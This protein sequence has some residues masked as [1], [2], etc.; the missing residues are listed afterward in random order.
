LPAVAIHDDI[1]K[2]YEIDLLGHIRILKRFWVYVKPYRSKF[3]LVFLL[4]LIAVPLQQF[5]IFL[6]RDVTNKALLATD[7]TF[8]ERWG[9]VL[10]IVGIQ[11]AFWFLSAI[12]STFREVLEWYTSMRATFD[13]R[14][15]FYKHLHRLPMTFLRQRPAGEQLYRATN[16]FGGQKQVD[17][18]GYDPGVMGMICRQFPQ[19]A[20]KAYMLIWGGVFL[21]MLDPGLGLILAVYMVPYL[22]VGWFLYDRVRR[23]AFQQRHRREIETGVLRDSIAGLRTVKS[24]GR[25][26]YQN[27]RYLRSAVLSGRRG[28]QQMA[29]TV[30]ADHIGLGGLRW[31]FNGTATAYISYRVLSGQA[32]VGD[33]FATVALLTAAQDPWEK[34]FTFV[35]KI[36]MDMV[37]AQRLLETL[38]VPIEQGDKADAQVLT[39]LEGAV[40]Y[41]DV[42]F[43]YD[44]GKPALKGVSFKVEP[45]E[46]I[47]FVGPSG[48]GKSSVL[49][50]LLR[51]YR[52]DSGQ[53]LVDG[54]DLQDAKLD[55]YLRFVGVVPQSTYLYDG[56][57]ADNILFG[58]K[59]A[60]PAELRQVALESGVAA[61]AARHAEGLDKPVGEGATISGG[62]RQ[63]IGIARALIR[64]PR[65]FV[66]DEATANLDAGTEAALL[67]TLRQVSKGRT[68]MIVAHRLKAVA[69]C[70]RI[71]VLDQGQ[72]VEVGKHEEL[73]KSGG[74]YARLWEEQSEETTL[75][76][77]AGGGR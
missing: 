73:I 2:R 60:T 34:L 47:G 28:M 43:S 38:D 56:S 22:L 76:L 18:D 29:N 70:D 55:S 41:K 45:G 14:I 32:T 71:F 6:T 39:H 65:I 4:L 48:A 15:H 53:V 42:W 61:F 9:T 26:R 35:Q 21:Y 68:S 64:N 74:L 20:E 11:A 37:P 27:R 19:L 54:V 57:I 58:R 31:L 36:R 7:L 10:R 8:H 17:G 50:L 33:W 77:A 16:D 72:I 13:L 3:L 51:L 66:L 69:H 12:L 75:K 52:P 23:A 44:E 1:D 5:S 67:K 59:D 49:N 30:L 46:N 62:E 40:E 63:R 24:M 25:D